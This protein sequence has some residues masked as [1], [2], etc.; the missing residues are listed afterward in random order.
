MRATGE[1][2]KERAQ[3]IIDKWERAGTAHIVTVPGVPAGYIPIGKLEEDGRFTPSSACEEFREGYIVAGKLKPATAYK[4]HLMMRALT[5]FAAVKNIHF[6]QQFDLGLLQKHQ[7]T[8]QLGA[9]AAIKRIEHLRTFFDYCVL[10]KWIGENPAGSRQHGRGFRTG[11]R[12]PEDTNT[13]K[14]PFSPEEMERIYEACWSFARQRERGTGDRCY[15]LVLLMRYT[16]LRISDAVMFHESRFTGNENEVVVYQRKVDGAPVTTWLPD[17]V[18]A[19]LRRQPTSDG[20]YFKAAS[21][22]PE[23]ARKLWTRHLNLVFEKAASKAPFSSHPHAHR[24]RHTFA[25]ELL[26]RGKDI[27]DVARLLG[28]SNWKTTE[29]YYSRWITARMER[30]R[31]VAKSAWTDEDHEHRPKLVRK[32]EA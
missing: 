19:V 6:V 9:K 14:E 18:I 32:A 20:Y 29:R 2:V 28:H 12:A 16:G 4:Y 26:K 21:D 10:R 5:E 3:A 24:F 25:A 22:D 1:T 15:A 23:N 11:L 13:R 7:A 27:Q 17:W 30:L 31:D 8:W